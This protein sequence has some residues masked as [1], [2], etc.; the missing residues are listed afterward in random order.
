MSK[1]ATLDWGAFH[2]GDIVVKDRKSIVKKTAATVHLAL[3]PKTAF[4]AIAAEAAGGDTWT[5]I[6]V[7]VLSIAD[8]LCVGIIIYA[9]ITWMFGNRTKAIE[10]LMGG[11]I[12]YLIVRHAVD[13]RNW[14]RTL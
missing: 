4:A 3:L 13:I 1:A 9:G 7:T 10:F 8:W 12:G 14:L 5:E 11:S 2:R 6:F